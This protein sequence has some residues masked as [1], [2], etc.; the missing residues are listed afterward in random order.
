MA[1][2]TDFEGKANNC[3]AEQLTHS[4][5]ECEQSNESSGASVKRKVR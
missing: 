2:K 5:S 4:G 1:C 3:V